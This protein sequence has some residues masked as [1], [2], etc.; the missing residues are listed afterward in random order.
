MSRR[1]LKLLFGWLE[2]VFIKFALCGLRRKRVRGR[3]T[4]EAWISKVTE[5]VCLFQIHFWDQF[6]FTTVWNT[7]ETADI[8]SS[9]FRMSVFILYLRDQGSRHSDTVC[10]TLVTMPIPSTIKSFCSL[11][12]QMGVSY[13]KSLHMNPKLTNIQ[14]EW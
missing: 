7:R 2:F 13:W 9:K 6:H 1:E 5:R 8:N 3:S 12:T 4:V 14:K 10:P 11:K